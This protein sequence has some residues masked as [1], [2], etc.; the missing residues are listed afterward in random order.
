MEEKVFNFQFT[1]KDIAVIKEGIGSV[2]LSKA[3]DTA[4]KIM[5]QY[6]EQIKEPIRKDK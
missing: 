3:F 6:S 2:P 5:N 4:I 1:E